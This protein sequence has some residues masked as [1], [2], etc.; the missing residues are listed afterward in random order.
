MKMFMMISLNR[1][2]RKVLKR[3][4]NRMNQYRKKRPIHTWKNITKISSKKEFNNRSFIK[5]KRKKK[6]LRNKI[7]RRRKKNRNK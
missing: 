5:K 4:N 2:M 3:R 7:R 1:I 6:E